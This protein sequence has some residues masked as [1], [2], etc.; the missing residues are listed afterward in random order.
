[1]VGIVVWHSVW[2]EDA[3]EILQSDR[4][5]K[6]QTCEIDKDDKFDEMPSDK[7]KLC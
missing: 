2:D 3:L 6:W 4:M 1:M 7:I 5:S